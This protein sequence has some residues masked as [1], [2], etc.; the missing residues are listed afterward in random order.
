MIGEPAETLVSDI[1]ES[2]H[3]LFDAYELLSLPTVPTLQS[4]LL[5]LASPCFDQ[6]SLMTASACRMALT[7]GLHRSDR[8]DGLMIYWSCI[9]AARWES[10]KSQKMQTESPLCFD[11]ETTCP[12]TVPDPDT[13]FGQVYQL[14][15]PAATDTN[16]AHTLN[17][18]SERHDCVQ[19]LACYLGHRA[20]DLQAICSAD[21]KGT[22]WY[23]LNPFHE[24]RFWA[25]E[26]A[27]KNTS[28]AVSPELPDPS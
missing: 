19:V 11:L 22:P 16:E 5:L 1:V 10:L 4:L 21:N 28:Q 23:R 15:M 12:R 24:A 17:P 20:E 27:T 3:Q 13:V 6:S 25:I 8:E 14:L 7:L 2:I 18:L 9:V 26:Q